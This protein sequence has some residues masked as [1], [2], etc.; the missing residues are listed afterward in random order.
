[1]IDSFWHD[2]HFARYAENRTFVYNIFVDFLFPKATENATQSFFKKLLQ[3]TFYKDTF[4]LK[5]EPVYF[6]FFRFVIGRSSSPASISLAWC[7]CT[8]SN[9]SR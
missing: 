6:R 1:M 5:P 4:F 8:L 7:T 9:S 2:S 3:T